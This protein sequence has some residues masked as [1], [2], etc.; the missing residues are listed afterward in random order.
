MLGIGIGFGPFYLNINYHGGFIAT[1][2]H[3]RDYKF[4]QNIGLIRPGVE[5]TFSLNSRFFSFFELEVGTKGALYL[6]T[7][8]YN[9]K[10]FYKIKTN[11]AMFHVRIPFSTEVEM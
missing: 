11:Y 10:E 2:L 8:V 7:R 4:D 5:G 6:P 1:L 9:D 3:Y